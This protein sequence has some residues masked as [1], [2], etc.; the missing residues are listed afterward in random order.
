MKTM[1]VCLV[2]IAA[3]TSGANADTNTLQSISTTLQARVGGAWSIATNSIT[4]YLA[5]KEL[6]PELKQGTYGVFVAVNDRSPLDLAKMWMEVCQAP[7]FILGT[8]AQCAVV[9]YV[10]RKHPVSQGIIK[11]LGLIEPKETSQTEG[12]SLRKPEGDNKPVVIGKV[13]TN[14]FRHTKEE[15]E[16]MERRKTATPMPGSIK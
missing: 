15:W 5:P 1:M 6:P 14:T 3:L 16:E 4:V 10:P 13:Y 2:A 12:M 8:N 7:F 11:A 9:T